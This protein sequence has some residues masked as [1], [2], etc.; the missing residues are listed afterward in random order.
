MKKNSLP[1]S[2]RY[3][4]KSK[5][6]RDFLSPLHSITSP[7]NKNDFKKISNSK[8]LNINGTSPIILY[9]KTQKINHR[10]QFDFNFLQSGDYVSDGGLKKKLE[11]FNTEK[12]IKENKSNSKIISPSNS[13]TMIKS[14]TSQSMKSIRKKEENNTNNF[15]N[16]S[17]Q[18]S[19]NNIKRN[20]YFSPPPKSPNYHYS[21]TIKKSNNKDNKTNRSNKDSKDSKEKKEKDLEKEK[22]LNKEEEEKKYMY[23]NQLIENGVAN[24]IRDFQI[25]KKLTVEEEMNEKKQKVLEENGI[26]INIDSL[27]NT[28]DDEIKEIENESNKININTDKIEEENNLNSNSTNTNN[29]VKSNKIVTPLNNNYLISNEN[30]IKK[31]YKPKVDHLEYIR[32]I[33]E[34]MRKIPGHISKRNSM[35]KSVSSKNRKKNYNENSFR[36]SYSND[37]NKSKNKNK[38]SSIEIDS[39]LK[40]VYD[41]D[42]NYLFSYRKNVRSIEEILTSIREKNEERKEKEEE[43]ELEKNKKIF[44][45]YKN[46]YSLTSKTQNNLTSKSTRKGSS[47]RKRIK[48]E[49]YVGSESNNSSTVIDANDYFLNVLESQ[50]LL[51]NGGL[52]RIDNQNI[53]NNQSISKEQIKKIT[54]KENSRVATEENKNSQES[55]LSSLK[56]KVNQTLTKSEKIIG[57]V[58]NN[59]IEKE[60]EKENLYNNDNNNYNNNIENYNEYDNNKIETNNIENDYN[61]KNIETDKYEN[62]ED[63]NN[64]LNKLINH[65]KDFENNQLEINIK[66]DNNKTP[67]NNDNES[68]SNIYT[69]DKNLPSL[70]HTYVG[71][72]NPNQKVIIEIEP[73][74]VLNLIGI[75]KFIYRRKIFY[76]LIEIYINE[77]ITQRYTV[78]FAFFTAIIKQ[79]PFRKIEEYSNYKTY[80]LAFFQLIKP[81]LKKIFKYFISC[82]YTKR[83]VEYFIEILSRLFKFKALEKIYDYS[84]DVENSEEALAFKL[85]LSR[86]M[87]L[88]MK[89][90]LKEAFN[91]FITNC[92]NENKKLKK[93]EIKRDYSAKSPFEN[94]R[95]HEIDLNEMNSNNTNYNKIIET[96]SSHSSIKNHKMKYNPLKMN[97]FTYESLDNS[98]KSSYTVEPNSVDNDRLHQLQLMLMAKRDELEFEN[99]PMDTG[100]DN[101]YEKKKLKT[102]S[103]KSSKSLQEICQMKPGLNLSKSL[104]DIS[105]DDIKKSISS[106]KSLQKSLSN[107]SL[108]ESKEKK[109]NNSSFNKS[110][111]KGKSLKE[112]IEEIKNNSIKYDKDKINKSDFEDIPSI[113]TKEE[114]MSIENKD[115][116]DKNDNDKKYTFNN[117]NDIEKN[118]KEE[119]NINNK[120]LKKENESKIINNENKN[121]EPDNIFNK[122]IKKDKPKDNKIINND[123]KFI[124]IDSNIPEEIVEKKVKPF[125]STSEADISADKDLEKKIDWEYSLTRTLSNDKSNNKSEEEKEENKQN[126]I[127]DNNINNNNNNNNKNNSNNK[128]DKKKIDEEIFIEDIENDNSNKE[129]SIEINKKDIK[130]NDK[131]NNNLNKKDERKNS[132]DDYGDFEDVSDIEKDEE[133]IISIIKNEAKQN[134]K[135]RNNLTNSPQR[136]EKKEIPENKIENNIINENDNKDNNEIPE[137]INFQIDN[138]DKFIDN[139]TEEILNNILNSEIKKEEKIFPKKLFKYDPFNNVQMNLSKSTSLSNSKELKENNLSLSN[140]PLKDNSLQALNDSLMSSYSAYSIFNKTVKEQKKEN[141]YR[142]YYNKIGPQLI[143]LIKNEIKNKYNEIYENISTPMKNQAKG[144]MVSLSLQDADMLR[145]N[146]KKNYIKKEI[147]QIINKEKLLKKFE[148]INKKIRKD[149][150]NKIDYFEYDQMLNNCLIDTTIELINKERLYGESGDPLPWSSRTHEISFKYDKNNP[151]KLC[152]Y[153]CKKLLFMLHNRI[154]LISENYDFLTGEQLNN[155]REKRFLNNVHKELDENEYLWKNLEMEETQLK[156]EV[157]EMIMEQLYNEIIEI[158]EHVQYSRKRPDLYQ[159]KSIYACEEIPKLSFQVTTTENLDSGDEENELMNM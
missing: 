134:D 110:E 62:E 9:K 149:D 36:Y 16:K 42:N 136:N 79:Y 48:N 49:Y 142:L 101:S 27:E 20:N 130:N 57:K 18:K 151:K 81:L 82:F 102:T 147:S 99:Y 150:N 120:D 12:I 1:S 143:I 113:L 89:P 56:E 71:T 95:N 109:S 137:I 54:E 121:E 6:S 145:D 117:N 158:L 33:Y 155:E 128:T 87:K 86:I 53:S 58:S 3:I 77:V 2:Y 65:K 88:T 61:N 31:I 152:D 21:K 35:A 126:K 139:I 111:N 98:S 73:R 154:G 72:T 4:Q 64:S 106:N 91:L 116:F 5:S 112:K 140:L 107:K 7:T 74:I 80:Y 78:G 129:N 34:E 52:Y 45:I 37:K 148:P 85:I 119:P 38:N 105:N 144:L 104:S 124:N 29:L 28:Q 55:N 11:K 41:D 15:K 70:S 96:N 25:E 123:N 23:M 115:D 47:K 19:K 51:V 50:Q 68:S 14:Q 153:I 90:K 69:K 26:E 92:K 46:L 97:S 141:S 44:T 22:K 94:N 39:K 132:I 108:N 60:K 13:K 131:R 159:Y 122:E 133:N 17:N 63:I 83:K 76:D 103:N 138:E 10:T 135:S 125:P 43:K 93:E 30:E 66:N 84:Q 100:S 118:I 127:S 24:Y 75:I 156:V 157:S 40:E 32:K 8:Q 146:Y 59:K 67:I 114:K